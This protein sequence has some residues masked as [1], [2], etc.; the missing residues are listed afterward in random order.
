MSDYTVEFSTESGRGLPLED[1]AGKGAP[2]Q[3]CNVGDQIICTVL[4]T[5]EGESVNPANVKITPAISSVATCI[6]GHPPSSDCLASGSWPYGSYSEEGFTPQTGSITTPY[7]LAI[8]M[9]DNVGVATFNAAAAANAKS[10]PIQTGAESQCSMDFS[11][12]V[13]L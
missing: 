9:L 1:S 2:P 4:Y 12:E 3:A 8:P 10:S 5:G 13:V 11:G 6:D 7:I